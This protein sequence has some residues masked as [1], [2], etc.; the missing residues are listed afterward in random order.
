MDN[1]NIRDNE[2]LENTIDTNIYEEAMDLILPGLQIF[3]RDVNL[4]PDLISKYR[5]GDII[6][7]KHF[8]D[9]SCRIQGMVTNTRYQILSNHMADFREF[10]EGTNWGLFVGQTNSR[11]KVIDVF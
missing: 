10:E 7:V 3:V 6:R 8:I 5:V 2:N 4:T 1:Q 9:A 11:F